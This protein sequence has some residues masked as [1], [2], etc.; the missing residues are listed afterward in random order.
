MPSR[1]RHAWL[2]CV[3]C[4]TGGLLA[5]VA[6]GQ[7]EDEG[8]T[9]ALQAEFEAEFHAFMAAPLYRPDTRGTYSLRGPEY[10]PK[11]L[12]FRHRTESMGPCSSFDRGG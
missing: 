2:V 8:K 10:S 3:C 9:V 5:P 6:E 7:V 1:L 11:A 4:L 12:A